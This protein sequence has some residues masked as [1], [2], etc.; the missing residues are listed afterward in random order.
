MKILSHGQWVLG[1]IKRREPS[2]LLAC[3]LLVA[4]AWGFVELASEVLEGDTGAF[5]RWMVRAMR[6]P[7]DL[8]TPL[9]PLWLQEMGR[10]AT[11]LGGMGSLT[12]FTL[13]VTGYLW[14]DN[15]R[16]MAWFVLA[17]T[18][19][20][21]LVSLGLKQV[22][23]RPRPDIVP[24]LSHVVT[25]SFPSGHSMLS[26]VV[27]LTLGALLAA[28]TARRVLKVYVL[29]VAMLLSMLVGI[30]RIYLGVHYPTDVLAGW[31]AG[32]VW[33]LFCLLLARWLQRFRH[34]EGEH[35]SPPVDRQ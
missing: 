27:Y 17:A 28:S 12:L 18:L 3:L 1:W 31:M 34:V 2:L 6:Q 10:D 33:A 30:S 5:D 32:L 35:P 14:L 29:A 13:A 20:G 23:G 24:Q 22:F 26:A 9:G 25:S 4:A 16:R 19:S 15:R 8:A 21:L 11:A 7:D